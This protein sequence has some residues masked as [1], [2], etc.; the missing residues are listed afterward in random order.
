[1][2]KKGFTLIELLVVIAIIGILSA[3]AVVS[4]SGARQKANDAKIKSDMNQMA[5]AAE[6][7]FADNS[8][9]GTAAT[10]SWVA[11]TT[12]VLGN[13]P[14]APDSYATNINFGTNGVSY[15]IVHPLCVTGA[16]NWCVD[17]T[18]YRGTSTAFTSSTASC[19]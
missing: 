8:N 6:T 9:Y 3:L 11:S 4:L 16:G 1:M 17:S 5:T 7:Y 14:C 12:P 10:V 15:V 18:G 13:A 2:N 19:K